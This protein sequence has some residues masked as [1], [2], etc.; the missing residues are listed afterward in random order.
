M[1]KFEFIKNNYSLDFLLSMPT[2]LQ[3][4]AILVA[5][6]L[7]IFTNQIIKNYV[8]GSAVNNWKIATDGLIRIIS[9]H[10][11]TM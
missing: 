10:N 6:G 11:F 9:R 4:C 3:L 7:S 2:L 8:I 5:L 1:N